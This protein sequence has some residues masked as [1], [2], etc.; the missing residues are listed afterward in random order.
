M[1]SSVLNTSWYSHQPSQEG[2]KELYRKR[3]FHISRTLAWLLRHSA[4][5]QCLYMRRDGYVCVQDLLNHPKL[6]GVSFIMLEDIVKRDMKQKF[7]LL[8]DP[9]K[10][11]SPGAPSQLQLTSWWIRANQG[12]SLRHIGVA[13]KRIVKVNEIPMAV[14]GTTVEAWKVIAKQGISRM[15]RK[16]IHL[17]QGAPGANVISGIRNTSRVL[18]FIDIERAMQNGIKFYLSDNGVILT[19]GNAY[20]LLEPCYFKKVEFVEIKTMLLDV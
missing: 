16:H 8:Y 5:Q 20:G 17:A 9:R 18:I 13:L 6:R 3:H 2:A 19:E 12:H 15:G 7:H 10:V 11:N 14:H 4:E 1:S